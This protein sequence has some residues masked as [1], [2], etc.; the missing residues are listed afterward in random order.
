M[1]QLGFFMMSGVSSVVVGPA[2]EVYPRKQLYCAVLCVG[3]APSLMMWLVPSG[4]FGY[5]VFLVARTFSGIAIGGS[6]PVM[7]SMLGDLFPASQRTMVTTVVT[8]ATAAGAGIGQAVAGFIGPSMG[9]RTPFVLFAMGSI[10][11]AAALTSVGVEPPRKT[12]EEARSSFANAGASAWGTVAP[13]R[14]AVDYSSMIRIFKTDS[15]RFIFMQGIVG[16]IGWS[17]IA[18]F[19]IDYLHVEQGLSVAQATLLMGVFGISVLCW[20]I[21]GGTVGQMLYNQKKEYVPMMLAAVYAVGPFP[22]WGIINF[23]LKRGE[24]SFGFLGFF[25]AAC[26]GVVGAAAPNIKALLMNVNT[27]SRRGAV[28]GAFTLT[29]AIGKGLGPILVCVLISIG[30]RR[31]AFSC[32]FLLWFFVVA[33]FLKIC[34]A[35]DRDVDLCD[36]EEPKDQDV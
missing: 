1:V 24:S 15:N 22:M 35:I 14:P 2:T 36:R 17:V 18:T 34:P 7:Y 11:F 30:G 25:L 8:V 29:E 12:K 4:G 16:Q 31:F 26:A 28:F 5:L 19:F 3:I 27:S 6:F 21:A 33:L 9:W 10:G 23:G 20:S 32:A 13:E